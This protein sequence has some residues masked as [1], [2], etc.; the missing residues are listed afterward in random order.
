MGFP[1]SPLI[2][3][4]FMEEFEVKALSSVPHASHLWLRY[5]DDTFVIQEA[6]HSQQ[7]LQHIN[8]KDP[9]IQFT[10]EEPNQGG[11]VPF[12][13]AVVSPGPSD[14]LITTVYRKPTHPDQYIHWDSNHI[15]TAKH[16]VFNT[17]AHRTK[18]VCTNQY[19]LHKEMDNIRKALQACSLP[20]WALNILHNKFNCKHNIHNG[21]TSTNN[22][23]NS[24]K[25]ISIEVPYIHE[26][27]K[28]SKGHAT[29]WGSRYISR[30]PTG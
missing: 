24:N 11:A 19:A 4:L 9:H 6:K 23:P 8:S 22:Q 28:G 20:P 17:L 13:D 26:G 25:N 21:Q 16:S 5:M 30:M 27:G 14:T 15:I 12:L 18:I 10:V 7:L 3:N 1:I 2:A 29:I